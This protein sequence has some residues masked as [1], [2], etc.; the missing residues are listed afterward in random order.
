MEAVIQWNTLAAMTDEGHAATSDPDAELMLRFKAGDLTAFE[1][2][3]ERYSSPLINFAFRFVHNREVAEE[4]AQ[5]IF[6]RVYDAAGS[7]RPE[8]RFTTWLYR[9]ATNACLNEVRRPRFR[10]IHHSLDS[11]PSGDPDATIPDIADRAAVSPDVCLERQDISQAMRQALSDLPEKQRLAFILNKYQEL[12][13]AEVASV[14]HISE[15]A[16][17]SLIH[18]AKETLA[19][20]LKRLLP[21]LVR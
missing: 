19:V 14:L 15:K 17:K 11:P 7:Y 13:Y 2:L 5:D 4:I 12:S 10:M 3:F 21:D 6:L 1:T 16:V 8:A 18:R 9:I 20:R